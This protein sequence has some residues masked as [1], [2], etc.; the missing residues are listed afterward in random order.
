MPKAR[1]ISFFAAFTAF[2]YFPGF[3]FF[4]FF[5]ALNDLTDTT[6]YEMDTD[7]TDGRD[8]WRAVM[9]VETLAARYVH[10]A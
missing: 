4:S 8:G 3:L 6:L 7:I 1:L 10:E 5:F 2:V 9:C